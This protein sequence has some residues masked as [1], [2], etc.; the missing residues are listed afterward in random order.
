MPATPGENENIPKWIL[1]NWMP[2]FAGMTRCFVIVIPVKTEI[3]K[4][5]DIMNNK[6]SGKTMKTLIRNGRHAFVVM[7]L[8]WVVFQN[9]YA[10][11]L[12]YPIEIID[13]ENKTI[14]INKKP[15]T[16][17]SLVPSISE[18]LFEIDA[19]DAVKGITHHSS[20]PPET[21]GKIII[22]GFFSPSMEHI[23]AIDPDIIFVSDLHQEIKNELTGIP[24]KVIN[25][26]TDSIKSGFDTILLLGKVF[27]REKQAE[28]IV[29]K[30]R[31][32]LTLIAQKTGKIPEE[33]RKRVIRLMGRDKVMTPGTDSFQ[34]E[35][36]RAAGGIAPDFGKAGSVVEVT[37]EE[38]QQ[39]N[40]QVIYGC[41]S[42]RPVADRFFSKPGWK[43]VPAVKNHQIYYLPCDLT[44]RASARTG[45]FVAGLSSMIY[46][47]DFSNPDNFVNSTAKI[48][49]KPLDIDLD[50]V[51]NAAV[52]SS[53][54]F[55]FVNKTLVVD[56]K[57]PMTVV[58]TLEGRR[59]GI[60]AVGN[61]YSPPPTWMP[62]HAKGIDD[63][64][65]FILT[66]IDRKRETTS[67]LMTG[68]NMDYLSVQ[69]R[70]F[71]EMSVTALI[72]AGV[73]SNAVRIGEDTGA[74]YE[75]AKP[76]T[77]N[78]IIMTNMRLSDRAMTRA[79]ISATEAKTA[80]IQ[81][82][83]IRSTYTP[84]VHMAS[85][86]GTDNVMVVQGRGTPIDNAGGHSKMGE[87][88]AKAVY[89]G[90]KE[91]MAGQNGIVP[92][93]HVVQ[94]L[95]ER[96]I[97]IYQLTSGAQCGC[98]ERKGEFSAMV[99]HL[100]LNPTYAGFLEAAL[101]LSDAYEQGLVQD[102][103]GFDV[104]CEQMAQ[105]IAGHKVDGLEDLVTDETVPLVI[106]KALNAIMTGAR[107][108]TSEE[109]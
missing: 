37:L 99:E 46:T 41:Y 8:I 74:W 102:L 2:A 62:G 15:E 22:G 51:D 70:T 23:K 65:N 60:T 109:G 49:S 78:V 16:V 80:V 94:R 89:A 75:P 90:V 59:E 95:K 79:I 39:F 52:I 101:S 21:T 38:W 71:K 20:F 105:R 34:N 66:A 45:A 76:G 19:G 55:D 43:E 6:K 73:T 98:R 13:S 28:E 56:L 97:S 25:L 7:T 50:Y 108:R 93:R 96:K 77:I 10:N 57:E 14:V 67:L 27:N 58:S 69:T 26:N 83:D 40:P 64:R 31:Q 48:S 87:L 3:Q 42:D 53:H 36:I 18:I 107:I 84:K 12:P 103:T 72:T 92:G 61:H 88:I 17:L 32:E 106:R 24:C 47:E 54:V 9:N 100:L 81:D 5:L 91:G 82:F 85:G 29:A 35:M 63:I 104:W 30:N 4:E 1:S 33:K 44:C 11:A 86:T 68:A